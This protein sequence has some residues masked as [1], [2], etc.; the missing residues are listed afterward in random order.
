MT[1]N[2]YVLRLE[3]GRYYVGKS[4][5]IMFRYRQHLDGNGSAWTRKYKPVLLD[6]MLENVSPFEEDKITKEFMA[7]YGIDKV[8]G[9]SYAEVHLSDYQI[10]S[11]NREIWSANDKC[12]LCGRDGHFK[13]NCYADTDICGNIIDRGESSDSDES[14]ESSED[15]D[16]YEDICEESEESEES[17]KDI[18]CEYCDRIFTDESEYNEHRRPCKFRNSPD[19]QYRG[20]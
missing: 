14:D 20:S 6:M 11:L 1:T 19:L 4:H 2:V 17:E 3:G 7:K 15:E 18:E 5:D 13:R 12:M 16:L 10:E 8:R 9:G